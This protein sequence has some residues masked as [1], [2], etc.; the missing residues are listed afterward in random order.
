MPW[1]I[2][3]AQLDKFR[4]SQKSLIIFDASWYL[5][6][7]HKTE[8]DARQEFTDKHII[9]SQFFD[10]DLFHETMGDNPHS[11]IL[12]RDEKRIGE[13]L[14]KLGIRNDYKIIFYDN[15]KLHTACRA[16]WM[17]KVFGHNPQLLYI[18]DGNID[19]WEKYGGKT[20]SGASLESAKN[21]QATFQPQYLRD[22]KD[23]KNNLSE[24]NSQVI[25]LRHAVRFCGGPELNP[26]V[27]RG[28][29]PDSASF[30]YITMF[31][32]NGTWRPLEKIRRQLIGI[33]IDL[34]AP[35]IT[36]CGSSITA[37][38]LNFALDLLGQPDNSV[39]AG[40]WA[41]WG[42]EKLYPGETSLAERPVA[43]CMDD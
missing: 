13:L 1:L 4:K 36:T 41:E 28:H 23:M 43:T 27:R 29:I 14:G 30:P 15:S 22:L 6:G 32:A 11:N 7:D 38:I 18:L 12:I 35:V 34:Q 10:L 17:L 16:L 5:P 9:G 31:D 19:I 39:Y 42:A 2:N 8:Q 37:P 3:P 21:Y 40:S 24:P 26:S 25:D 20:E 33:D